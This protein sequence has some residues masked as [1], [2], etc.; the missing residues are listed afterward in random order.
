MSAETSEARS[1]GAEELPALLRGVEVVLL[2]ATEVEA[3]PMRDGL[4]VRDRLRVAGKDWTWGTVETVR[5]PVS[6]ALLV[7]GC[8][9]ANA[10]HV[11]TCLLQAHRPRL[12]LQSG[13]G[14]G[15]ARAGVGIGDVV[16][17]TS[18]AYGDTGSSTPE[19]WMGMDRLGLP[20]VED[21]ARTCFNEFPLDPG[22]VAAVVEVLV[23]GA[24]S[25]DP[26]AATEASRVVPGPFLTLSRV[27][28]TDGEAAELEHRWHPV[29]ESMEGAAA[30]QVCALYG[31]PFLE[32]RGV[33]NLVGD[34]DRE[35]WDLPGAAARAAAAVLRLCKRLEDLPMPPPSVPPGPGIGAGRRLLDRDDHADHGVTEEP[36]LLAFSPCPN[37]T[38]IFHAWVS[39]HVPGAP[40]V[41][42]RL[43]DIDMLNTLALEGR[44]DVVKISFHAFGHLRERYALLH[45]GGAL[46]RGCGP[47]LVA[48][49]DSDLIEGAG[50]SA[51]GDLAAGALEADR[52]RPAPALAGV[53]IA[54][55]GPLTTAALLLRLFAPQARNW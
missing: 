48:R 24:G 36:L 10:A 5:R 19:G 21:G 39:G 15:F 50:L 25:P 7:T 16:V 12:V 28:G 9:K 46:G 55:P 35:A 3:A 27:T 2:V 44:P 18:E 23:E 43:D 13:V 42:P 41:T 30:A 38:F 37:D 53:R 45:S 1:A 17:A 11:L 49:A 34:R 31:V 26:P 8:D 40:P 47:L 29:A 6:V 32:V 54:I 33:S 20:L 14:G 52:Y 22:L 4:S 51:G